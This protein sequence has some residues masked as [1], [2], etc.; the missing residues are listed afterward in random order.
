[1]HG[2]NRKLVKQHKGRY[3]ITQKQ[4]FFPTL[5]ELVSYQN[6][7]SHWNK[8]DCPTFAKDGNTQ[9]AEGT[10]HAVYWE[11]SNYLATEFIYRW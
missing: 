11:I 5:N 7:Q 10:E 1:M 2:Y 4:I 3:L 6:S 8:G 9:V